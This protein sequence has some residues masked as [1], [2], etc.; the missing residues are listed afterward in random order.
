MTPIPRAA[1]V[2]L[3]ATLKRPPL[4]LFSA[5]AVSAISSDVEGR[6]TTDSPVPPTFSVIQ[7]QVDASIAVVNQLLLDYE[8]Q[9]ASLA[10]L[11]ETHRT[12]LQEMKLRPDLDEYQDELVSLRSSWKDGLARC[13]DI[14]YC[15]DVALSALQKSTEVAILSAPLF[16][17]SS[18][19]HKSEDLSVSD[20]AAQMLNSFD[21]SLVDLRQRQTRLV[22]SWIEDE[23]EHIKNVKS[24]E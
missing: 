14:T 19:T 22:A 17:P 18:A 16:F 8:F 4:L 2:P 23:S 3:L 12:L 15:I 13:T 11:N 20:R 5:T 21:A 9:L 10:K 7:L 6:H 1:C 24:P